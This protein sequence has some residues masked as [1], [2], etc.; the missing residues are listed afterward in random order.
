M[1]QRDLRCQHR[2]FERWP[3]WGTWQTVM[4]RCYASGLQT[5]AAIGRVAQALNDDPPP[6]RPSILRT[7]GGRLRLNTVFGQLRWPGQ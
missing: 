2:A 1:I 7:G 3:D 4:A 6:D 5:D